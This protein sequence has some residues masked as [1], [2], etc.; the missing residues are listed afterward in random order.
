MKTLLQKGNVEVTKMEQIGFV[1]CMIILNAFALASLITQ[2]YDPPP[3]LAL[4]ILLAAL[5]LTC[6]IG[7]A[8]AICD[9]D[10]ED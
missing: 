6:F 2:K 1:L 10:V 3:T 8:M 4:N 5:S 9:P 7:S